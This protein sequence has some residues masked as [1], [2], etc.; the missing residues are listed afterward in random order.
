M[1]WDKTIP[2]DDELLSN[3]PALCRANWDALELLTASALQVTNAK[4]ATGANIADTKLA[5]ITTP[6][7]VSGAAI[8][9][10][11]SVPSGA[12]VLPDANSPHKLKADSADT[13][14]QYLDSLI[15]T[16]MFQISAG[17]LLQVKDE[18]IG[19][20]KLVGG[21]ASPGNTKYYGTNP[22]GTKGFHDFPTQTVF[23]AYRATSDQTVG[24]GAT[25]KIQLNAEDADSHNLF[26]ST[27][28]YRFTVTA[29]YE[30]YYDVSASVRFDGG[31]SGNSFSIMIYKNGS[32]F[33]RV[34]IN[35]HSGA[36]SIPIACVIPLLTAGDY[37]EL[38]VENGGSNSQV[39]TKDRFNTWME[40][41][42]TA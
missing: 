42:R 30:G 31:T 8:T 3:F 10:L 16:G 37:L 4:V 25:A 19:T 13:T 28:N 14:P 22:S 18:G 9:S 12:G 33:K 2:A 36:F 23:S 17:D 7:K 20:E 34:S 40:G 41:S 5:Q 32:L 29:G 38:Y 1:A 27:T 21:S 39:V 26:D 6:S 24:A 15:D 35:A 11:A